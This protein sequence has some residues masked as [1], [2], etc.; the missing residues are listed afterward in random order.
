MGNTYTVLMLGDVCGQPGMRALFI[1][2]GQL[3]KEHRADFVVVNGENAANGFGLNESE[4]TQL[5]SLGVNV[6]TSGNHIWQQDEIYDSLKND[7]RLLRPLNYPSGTIGHGS[8]IIENNG[9]KVGVINLQGRLSLPQT[10]C[11]FRA[12]EDEIKK[13]NGKCDII[14][15]DMHAENHEEKKAL[16]MYLDGKVSAVVG[17]HTHV[18]TAD[19]MILENGTAFITDLGLCGPSD[20]V[21][22]SDPEISIKKQLTQMP[23]RTQIH[24]TAP[25]INGVVIEIDKKSSKAISISRI[26][27]QL[28]V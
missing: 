12:A 18:Q 2:L 15:I 11:P 7:N 25:V 5:F 14:L 22:G 26:N 9:V 4:K 20:S 13:M 8:T 21:I 28:L 27:K 1:G 24:T 17:T 3:I 19:E 10:D 6:I 16:A 23:I